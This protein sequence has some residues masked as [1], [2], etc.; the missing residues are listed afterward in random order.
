MVAGGGMIQFEAED[1]ERD[2]PYCNGYH[3]LLPGY[4]DL[5]TH[6]AVDPIPPE[7]VHTHPQVGQRK[8][9]AGGGYVPDLTRFDNPS[10]DQALN[11]PQ[12]TGQGVGVATRESR[13]AKKTKTSPNKPLPT[14]PIPSRDGMSTTSQSR[15]VTRHQKTS[16]NPGH[17]PSQNSQPITTRPTLRVPI[18]SQENERKP[19]DQPLIGST[20][21]PTTSG[22]EDLEERQGLPPRGSQLV[23][24][25]KTDA[26]TESSLMQALPPNAN[27]TA[28]VSTVNSL[29][30]SQAQMFM[31]MMSTMK[32]LSSKVD[33]LGDRGGGG[34][35]SSS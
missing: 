27:L 7:V 4:S 34:A 32:E 9:R 6:Y 8:C 28:V 12:G 13:K 29:V 11:L 14:P 35:S 19:P 31:A 3:I 10:M 23:R 20:S 1:W 21:G 26:N 2:H 17:G 18:T 30:E 16:S 5:R 15:V 24:K 25:R 33:A 22:Q